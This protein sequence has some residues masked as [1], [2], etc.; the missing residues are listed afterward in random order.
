MSNKKEEKSCLNCGRVIDIK[1]DTYVILETIQTEKTIEKKH[2]HLS[3][4]KDYINKAVQ[5][6]TSFKLK[7][8]MKKA[9]SILNNMGI[10][11]INL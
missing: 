11:V 9:G 2:F 4:W 6:K 10:P 3:C 8:A 1:R 5:L 7:D